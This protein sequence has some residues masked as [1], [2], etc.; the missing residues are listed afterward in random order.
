M[1]TL[2]LSRYCLLSLQGGINMASF[3]EVVSAQSQ[4]LS[5]LP[6]RSE[7]L[8]RYH[9]SDALFFKPYHETFNQ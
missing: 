8:Q 7:R 5:P 6:V 2:Q 3:V 1:N 9:Q 4:I